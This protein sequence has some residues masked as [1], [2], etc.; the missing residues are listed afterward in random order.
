MGGQATQ[1]AC[2]DAMRTVFALPWPG[3]GREAGVASVTR[4]GPSPTGPGGAV[5]RGHRVEAL[6]RTHKHCG[7][8]PPLR[9]PAEGCALLLIGM[10]LEYCTVLVGTF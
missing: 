7:G 1:S 3:E 4:L 5:Q 10:T 2:L 8:L 6:G 9:S